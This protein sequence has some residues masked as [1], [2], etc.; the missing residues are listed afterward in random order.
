VTH[1]LSA[2]SSL[3]IG[4]I[5]VVA[6]WWTEVWDA[7]VLLQPWPLLRSAILS[8]FARGAVSGLGLVNVLLAVQE[9]REHFEE[10]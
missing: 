9:V 1:L 5:L 8:P 6:P 10:R 4:A 7:N 3:L 2:L